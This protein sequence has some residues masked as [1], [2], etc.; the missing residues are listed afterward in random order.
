M[1]A[2]TNLCANCGTEFAEAFLPKAVQVYCSF[3]CH[4]EATREAQP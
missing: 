3:M 1:T 4:L 2:S